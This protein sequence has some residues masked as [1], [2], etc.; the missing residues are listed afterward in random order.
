MTY[1][2]QMLPSRAPA[3]DDAPWEPVTLPQTVNAS[4]LGAMLRHAEDLEFDADGQ[5]KYRITEDDEPAFDYVDHFI[6]AERKWVK[7]AT[8]VSARRVA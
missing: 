7:I 1:A 2:I 8:P 4:D 6:E 3:S 5:T